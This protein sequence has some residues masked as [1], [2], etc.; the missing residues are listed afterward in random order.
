METEDALRKL[1]IDP[2]MHIFY[3]TAEEAFENISKV[4][5]EYCPHVDL[6]KLSKSEILKLFRDYGECLLLYH[7]EKN[8]PERAAILRNISIFRKYNLTDED[9]NTLDFD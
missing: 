7:P 1:G 9:I 8:H 4:I 6:T 2:H 3:V 5:K